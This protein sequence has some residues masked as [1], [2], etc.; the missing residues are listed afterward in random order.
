VTILRQEETNAQALSNGVD[1]LTRYRYRCERQW[2]S[3]SSSSGDDSSRDDEAQT[4]KNVRMSDDE[5]D[6]FEREHGWS[7]SAAG[8]RVVASPRL[9]VLAKSTSRWRLKATRSRVAVEDDTKA[10]AAST[11]QTRGRSHSLGRAFTA[12]L[13]R[14]STKANLRSA[15][16]SQVP[17]VPAL[18]S[19]LKQAGV[20]K[21]KS[22][23]NLRDGGDGGVIGDWTA[24]FIIG[25]VAS[26]SRSRLAGNEDS[27]DESGGDE[28][29][30]D[31]CESDET[32]RRPRE[33]WPTE[34]LDFKGKRR[35][36]QVPVGCC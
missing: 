6:L 7:G 23:A 11:P 33:R 10:A 8:I 22:V 14:R 5:L 30:K 12:V 27:E 26:R 29:V 16:A 15:A 34:E 24:A 17:P 21:S 32:G 28:V 18:P 31:D 20:N 1:G 13:S 3:S 19:S 36:A 35:T 9:K 4:I 2:S 25:K